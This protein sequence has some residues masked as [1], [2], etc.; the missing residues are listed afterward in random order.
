MSELFDKNSRKRIKSAPF[1]GAAI[2]SAA[3]KSIILVGLGPH[4]KRIYMHYLRKHNISP[5]LIVELDSKR[6]EVESYLASNNL[7][8]ETAYIADRERD[9]EE[10]SPSVQAELKRLIEK[11]GITHVILSTEPK[12]HYAYLKFFLRQNVSILTDKPITAPNHVSTDKK[13]A[14]RI[15]EEYEELLDLYKIARENGARCEVQC[16]RRWHEGYRY[17]RNILAECIRQTG[18]PITRMDIHHCDGMWNMPNEFIFRENHPY[19]YGYGK[20][21]HSG[22]HFIDLMCWLIKLNEPLDTKTSDSVE[23][24][25]AATRP[26]DFMEIFNRSDYRN[27]FGANLFEHEFRLREKGYFDSFGETD[28]FGLMQFKRNERVITTCSLSLMQTGFSRRSWIQLPPDTYKSNGRVRHERLDVQIG[29]LMNI[30]VHSYQSKEIKE[31]KPDDTHDVGLLEHF[32]IYIFRNSDLIG[33]KPFEK[34]GITDLLGRQ[35]IETKSFIGYNEKARENCLIGFLNN[36]SEYSDL[37]D[38]HLTV[39]VLTNAYLSLCQRH[40]GSSPIV[41]FKVEKRV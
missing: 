1:D 5:A 18:I 30:Q 28:F 14:L 4:A 10:L 41:K 16:Q 9:N 21:F 29:H 13:M 26:D 22:Y 3:D 40:E 38:H 31:R 12:A 7:E 19:K 20:L 39:K 27:L 11:L 24:Y 2:S 33:G 25:A 23:L 17:V 8:V 15:A 32:D 34:I 36:L 37:T 6:S 35:S